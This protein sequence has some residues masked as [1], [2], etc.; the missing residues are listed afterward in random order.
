MRVHIVKPYDLNKD[1]ARAYNETMKLIP[2]GDWACLCDYDTMMLTPDCGLILHNYAEKFAHAGIMTCFTNRVHEI[3]VDQLLGGKVSN[4][5]DLKYH[6]GLAQQQK[7]HLYNVTPLNGCISGY[8]MMVKKETWDKIKFLEGIGCLGIDTY[9]SR[10]ILESGLS[11]YR[12]DGL[13]LWHTYR[14]IKG[15]HNKEHLL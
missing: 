12:M 5:T 7:R 6:I 3:S 2:D 15:V 13:Y 9:F 11:I 10:E 1:L 14:L 8:L 4:N